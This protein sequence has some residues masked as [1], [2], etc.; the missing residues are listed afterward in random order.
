MRRL[1]IVLAVF[2]TCASASAIPVE[3]TG[4]SI[5]MN[6]THPAPFSDVEALLLGDTFTLTN[7]LTQSNF[8]FVGSNPGFF[9]H[10]LGDVLNFSGHSD[11]LSPFDSLTYLGTSYGASG[12]FDVFVGD[13]NYGGQE[14]LTVPFLFTG[15][16]LGDPGGLAFEL[17][18]GGTMTAIFAPLGDPFHQ[19]EL[20]GIS[21][22]FE[23]HGTC[24]VFCV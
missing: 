2:L 16:V 11:L 15:S 5:K 8:E 10:V 3:I 23:P 6:Q 14:L 21:Y 20:R 1:L 12:F 9:T 24:Q 4:G 22:D 19:F 17:F 7:N 18:G 13:L